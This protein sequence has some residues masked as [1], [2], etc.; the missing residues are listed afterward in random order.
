[1]AQRPLT[2]SGVDLLHAIQPCHS[3]EEE[4]NSLAEPLP[5]RMIITLC[6]SFIRIVNESGIQYVYLVHQTAKEY[7]LQNQSLDSAQI[8]PL[9]Y[10]STITDCHM[11]LVVRCIRFLLFRELDTKLLP[12]WSGNEQKDFKSYVQ[13]FARNRV[14][15][16][17]TAAHW[18]THLRESETIA[19]SETLTQSLSLYDQGSSRYVTWSQ[20]Y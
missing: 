16:S 4:V 17:Y 8:S 19:D 12:K 5:Y 2:V 1:V 18:S 11:A 3:S 13:D 6:G 20:V 7:L 14:L 15:L 10:S 9:W